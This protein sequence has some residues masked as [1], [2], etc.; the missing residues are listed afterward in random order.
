MNAIGIRCAVI[1]LG[2]GRNHVR[3]IE[4]HSR[5]TVAALCDFD[6]GA[7]EE[8]RRWRPGYPVHADADAVLSDP[9]VDLVVVASYDDHHCAQIVAALEAG[10]HVFAEKPLCL[11]PHEAAAIRAALER[12]PDLRL[13]A[14]HVLRTCPR[15]IRLRDMIRSGDMGRVY[16]MEGDYLWGRGRKLESGW[17]VDMDFYSIIHGAA[18][19]LV[20]LLMWFTSNRPQWVTAAGNAIALGGG[21]LRHND[22]ALLT[23]G[24]EDGL[25]AKVSAHG[26]CAHPHHHRVA[27]YG[28]RRTFCNEYRGGV[29]FSS[30]SPE[31]GPHED[32]EADAM[33]YPV[34]EMRGGVLA[35]FLD[36]VLDYAAPPPV[37]AGEVFDAM[38][39]CFAAQRAMETGVKQF[40]TY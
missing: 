36:H 26:G 7:A 29:W 22:F 8:A 20:D 38:A 12:R 18:V 30:S 3:T 27:V 4:A 13:S 37:P 25:M 2:V 33:A 19:H 31:V 21:R 9:S 24:F 10:K 34:R 1:G 15:F 6:P 14:N 23:L 16:H 28:T 40:P 17:R 35:G 5:A 39:V 11:F 32:P